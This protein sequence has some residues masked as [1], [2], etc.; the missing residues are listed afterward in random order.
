MTTCGVRVRNI[1]IFARN[2]NITSEQPVSFQSSRLLI[3]QSQSLRCTTVNKVR[4]HTF[5]LVLILMSLEIMIYKFCNNIVAFN[6]CV[7]IKKTL[8]NCLWKVVMSSNVLHLFNS[9]IS[10]LREPSKFKTIYRFFGSLFFSVFK[11]K[12]YKDRGVFTFCFVNLQ[13][14]GSHKPTQKLLR[15]FLSWYL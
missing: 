8:E 9:N 14:E 10:I 15:P 3:L 12:L 11:G 2:N 5:I 1:D 4:K 7:T 13:L 6:Q